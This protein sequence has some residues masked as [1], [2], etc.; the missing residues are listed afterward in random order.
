M[1][2][3]SEEVE[4][5]ENGMMEILNYFLAKEFLGK[6]NDGC[7]VNW[8]SQ[9]GLIYTR[10]PDCKAITYQLLSTKEKIIELLDLSEK[11]GISIEE[12]GISDLNNDNSQFDSKLT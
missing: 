2:Q 11:N 3:V 10:T 8:T 1:V 7:L 12:I 6:N 5:E 9:L 4:V